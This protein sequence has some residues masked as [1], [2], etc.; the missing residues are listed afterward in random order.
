M[1][2]GVLTA[3]NQLTAIIAAPSMLLQDHA[4]L[5]L[6]LLPFLILLQLAPVCSCHKAL[7]VVIQVVLLAALLQL[8]GA[9]DMWF[10]ERV[11]RNSQT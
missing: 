10:Y 5:P 6:L 4:P 2:I 3:T 8:Q 1:L 11:A 7:A 9:R